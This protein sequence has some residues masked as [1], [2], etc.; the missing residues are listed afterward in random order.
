MGTPLN[1]NP[2]AHGVRRPGDFRRRGADGPPIVPSVTKTRQPA[3]LKADLIAKC[4]D[5]GIEVPDKATVAVLKELLGPEPADETYGR[6][7]G[8]GAALDNP[9]AL[10]KWKERQVALG[11][12]MRPTLLDRLHNID[13]EQEREVLDG[14]VAQA[15]EAAG[16]SLSADR[17][18]HVH[19]LTERHDRGE[20]WDDLLPAG[21]SLGIPAPLQRQVVA[22]WAAF[23]QTM[24]LT[25][26]HVEAPVVCDEWRLAGT[27][28]RIDVCAVDIVTPHGHVIKAGTPFV[29]DVKTSQYRTRG[30]QPMYW[31]T[32]GP[33]IAAYADGVPFDVDAEERGEWAKPIHKSAAL[34]YNFDLTRAL[35][36][37]VVEWLAIPIDL[38]VARE[39][40][41]IAA[42]AAEFARRDDMF[43]APIS[44]ASSPEADD[45]PAALPAAVE[46]T[47][48]ST[49]AQPRI[50]VDPAVELAN[51][52]AS[53]GGP[54][55]KMLVDVWPSGLASPKS[56][57]QGA[58]TWAGADL[59]AAQ[60]AVDVVVGGFTE[61]A[62]T[63][64]PAERPAQPAP[65]KRV[66]DGRTLDAEVVNS[67]LAVVKASPVR[68]I[69]NGWLHEASEAGMSWQPRLGR[70]ERHVEITRAAF[71]LASII[72]DAP[73]DA[74]DE[75]FT[76]IV[77]G[78][79][80]SVVGSDQAL[81]PATPIGVML[82]HLTIEEALS[83]TSTAQAVEGGGLAPIF[84]DGPVTFRDV[85]NETAA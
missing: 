82:A 47:A 22:K 51:S 83:V 55:K 26:L 23:R 48:G 4:V 70:R 16:S 15:H 42:E 41:R 49:E 35:D 13:P 74:T 10:I 77:R 79:L 25:A 27:T 11:I 38:T 36:G 37:E 29:G 14:I 43:G 7:S 2:R 85:S 69:V 80:A 21:K 18:T 53:W 78:V 59:A 84:S 67:L 50:E 46:Q 60:A 73:Q 61:V 20:T 17:G 9:H 12:S 33:Q 8:F 44:S 64:A 66:D 30:D 68:S 72:G 58:A 28:D 24:Q 40:A 56:V 63:A 57:R 39:G 31:L 19:L 81:M 6:P 45:A 32:Y 54:L 76:G 34:I 52:I 65:A 3:G 1:T 62:E 75:A 5:R 71:A